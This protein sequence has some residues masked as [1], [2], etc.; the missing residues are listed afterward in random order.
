MNRSHL[1]LLLIATL[2][3]TGASFW[4]APFPSE[5]RLQHIPTV[6]GIIGLWAVVERKWLRPLSVICL[7]AFLWLHILGARWIYSFVPYDLWVERICGA[8]CAEMFSWKRNHYDRFVHLASG[9]L[10]V[11][12][13]W[14][15]LQR[16]GLTGAGGLAIVSVS[17]VLGMGAVYEILEWAISLLFAPAY[18]ESYNGQQGDL[19]DPQKDMA[20]AGLGA[21]AMAGGL[22]GR[23]SLGCRRAKHTDTSE[24]CPTKSITESGPASAQT[25]RGSSAFSIVTRS[26]SPDPTGSH[27]QTG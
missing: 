10:F 11:P 5:L 8:S 3:A 2:V 16:R 18:A 21:I 14:E 15:L 25:L 27:P 26:L 20:L 22:L 24:S 13:T 23:S 1:L 12:P 9:L 7:L 17:V 19:W 6:V 4:Q